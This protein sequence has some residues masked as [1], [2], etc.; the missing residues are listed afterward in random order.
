MVPVLPA[1]STRVQPPGHSFYVKKKD[2]HATHKVDFT[3]TLDF[4]FFDYQLRPDLG[5]S[6]SFNLDFA[7]IPRSRLVSEYH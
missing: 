6:T 4:N 7:P 1:Y 5:A 2:S 3:A